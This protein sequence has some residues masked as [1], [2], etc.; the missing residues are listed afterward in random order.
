[1][2]LAKIFYCFFCNTRP[3]LIVAHIPRSGYIP[4]EIIEIQTDVSNVSGIPVQAIKFDLKKV[5]FF[6][7]TLLTAVK[8]WLVHFVVEIV[9]RY[10]IRFR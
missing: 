9:V 6:F 4:G 3:L 5:W 7:Y 10:T 1:M 2:N 8:T